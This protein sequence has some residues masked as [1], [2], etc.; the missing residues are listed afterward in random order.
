VIERRK[1]CHDGDV[2]LL[3]AFRARDGGI[4]LLSVGSEIRAWDPATGDHVA[5][6]DDVGSSWNY[7]EVCHPVGR[8]PVLAVAT[9]DGVEWFDAVTGARCYEDTLVG[10]VWGLATARMRNGPD[11]LFG[12]GHMAPYPIHRWD[13]GT[14]AMLPDL[15]EHDDHI[16]AVA[17]VVLP[18]GSV[19][20]AATGWSH[21][22]HRWDPATGSEYGPPLEGHTGIVNDMDA[23]T[24]P[25]GRVLLLSGDSGGV[26]RRW[27]AVTG[28]PVGDPIKAHPENATVLAMRAT[29]KPQMLT[30]GNDQ[31]IRR[32]DAATGELLDEPASGF[33]PILLTIDGTLGIAAGGARG[34]FVEP[35]HLS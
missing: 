30:S 2:W 4:R 33:N 23:V 24:L 34:L 5:T 32:W 28:E 15:G 10:T 13:A 7:V 14:G 35:L 6:F 31:V 19:M 18:G 8:D 9:E 3:K 29:G 27:D 22:I 20:A 25:D 16:V 21:T 1:L 11:V 12:A 26:V 17:A